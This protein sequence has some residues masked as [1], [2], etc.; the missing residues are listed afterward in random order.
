MVEF[1]V[2]LIEEDEESTVNLLNHVPTRVGIKTRGKMDV[3]ASGKGKQ[4]EFEM[5]NPQSKFENA[6]LHLVEE[7]LDRS[8]NCDITVDDID[9]ESF[10]EIAKHYWK[11][12]RGERAK[13]SNTG[14]DTT[15]G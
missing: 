15:S 8:P 11:Q 9:Y 7:M 5:D 4:V 6:K 10:N 1:T 14:S 3:Q 2:T 12:V 13:N